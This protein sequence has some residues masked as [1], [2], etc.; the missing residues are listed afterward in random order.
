M[1]KLNKSKFESLIKSNDEIK[2]LGFN[3]RKNIF[4]KFISSYIYYNDTMQPIVLKFDGFAE[5]LINQIKY[6]KKHYNYAIRK[7]NENHN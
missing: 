1:E 3:Y 6:I 5:I 7:N 4:R 2:H